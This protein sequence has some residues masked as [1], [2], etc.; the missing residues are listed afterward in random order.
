MHR[1]QYKVNKITYY[2]Y[3]YNACLYLSTSTI[4][5]MQHMYHICINIEQNIENTQKLIVVINDDNKMQ[6][7]IE[8]SIK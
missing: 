2:L 4:R 3:S 7:Y 1:I 5:A 6:H 8:G